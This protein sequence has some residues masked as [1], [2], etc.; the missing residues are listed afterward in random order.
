MFGDRVLALDENGE[1]VREIQV[2]D[3]PS[4]LGWLVDGRLLIVLMHSRAVVAVNDAGDV[5]PY[6]D[7]SNFGRGP[8]ND[9]VTD[10]SGRA[11][12][13]YLGF[14]M[15][16]GETPRPTDLVRV[17]VDGSVHLAASGLMTPNGAAVVE[18]PSLLIAETLA[19]RITTFTITRDGRLADR[20][21]FIQL[22]PAPPY[23]DLR[24][25]LRALAAAPDGV[26]A[27]ADGRLWV[28]DAAGRACVLVDRCGEVV[29]R[30]AAPQAQHSFA[31]A[32]GGANGRTLLVCCAPDAFEARRAGHLDARLFATTLPMRFP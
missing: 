32:V 15:A 7:L 11:W 14:D 26:A 13:G 18:G 2:D 1:V 19:S 24:T 8:A 10:R 6:A 29:A 16:G 28:A 23:D 30:V 12:V 9:L 5:T 21:V 4:G 17:D 22:A 25:C 31:C 27:G 3:H 20:R